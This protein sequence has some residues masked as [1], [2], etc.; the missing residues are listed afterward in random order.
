MLEGG[1]LMRVPALGVLSCA[2]LHRAGRVTVQRSGSQEARSGGE[3]YHDDFSLCG[4]LG[5]YL[6]DLKLRAREETDAGLSA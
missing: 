2:S 5:T 1:R 6:S 4:A 3:G